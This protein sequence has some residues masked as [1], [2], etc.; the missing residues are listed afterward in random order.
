MKCVDRFRL[1]KSRRDATNQT[2]RSSHSN[3]T[4]AMRSSG[5]THLTKKPQLSFSKG[6]SYCRGFP[7]SEEG[8][9]EA[10]AGP[11]ATPTRLSSLFVTPARAYVRVSHLYSYSSAHTEK[12]IARMWLNNSRNFW[13]YVLPRAHDTRLRGAGGCKQNSST[14]PR[15]IESQI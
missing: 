12:S 5:S 1:R 7:K 2:R 4:C 13:H 6:F 3:P 14:R 15:F 11:L 10:V 8:A 9:M